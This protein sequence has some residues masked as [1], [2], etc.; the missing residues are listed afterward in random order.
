MASIKSRIS[1]LEQSHTATTRRQ[2]TDAELAVR[3]VHIFNDPGCSPLHAPLR[4]LLHRT[5]V[6]NAQPQ[7]DV[8]A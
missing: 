2:W 3:L 8:P 6:A 1:V 5:A 4:A 7:A